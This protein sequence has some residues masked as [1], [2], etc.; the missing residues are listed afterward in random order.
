MRLEVIAFCIKPDPGQEEA[1]VYDQALEDL[2]SLVTRAE[3]SRRVIARQRPSRLLDALE[4]LVE[5]EKFVFSQGARKVA[6]L[7]SEKKYELPLPASWN[8]CPLF[9]QR[10]GGR[11]P[12]RPRPT[13]KSK[14]A[15]SSSCSTSMSGKPEAVPNLLFLKPSLEHV[16]SLRD[17]ALVEGPDG[18]SQYDVKVD[19][20]EEEQWPGARFA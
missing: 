7:D 14:E 16:A 15:S 20:G 4:K 12:P 17:H 6:E 5:T 3:P 8:L 11:R 19:L 9:D 10:Q 13:W 1:N 2:K 18:Q